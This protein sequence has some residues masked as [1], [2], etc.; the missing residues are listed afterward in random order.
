M[1]TNSIV[2]T[3]TYESLGPVTGWVSLDSTIREM[4]DDNH[5]VR[6]DQNCVC[7]SN[8]YV[9]R[10]SIYQGWQSLTINEFGIT[11]GASKQQRSGWVVAFWQLGGPD[12][13]HDVDTRLKSLIPSSLGLASETKRWS[14][15]GYSP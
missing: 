2:C 7:A 15:L 10:E 5:E 11:P 13:V 12:R 1:E 6:T 8:P 3:N 9:Q 4:L 14:S